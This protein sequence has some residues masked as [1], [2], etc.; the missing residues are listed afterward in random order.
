[1]NE[2]FIYAVIENDGES[3]P[4][5]ESRTGG[6]DGAPLEIVPYRDLAAVVSSIDASRFDTDLPAKRMAALSGKASS[7]QKEERLKADMLRYQQVNLFLLEHSGCSGMVPLRFGFT[8]RDKEQVEEVLGRVY[9]QLRTLLNNLKGKVELV[10]HASWD[11]PKILQEIRDE[12]GILSQRSESALGGLTEDGFPD[13][14]NPQSEI[15]NPKSIVEVGRMLFEGAEVRRKKFIE[16]IHNNLSPL[17]KDFSEGPRKAEAMILNR[18]YLVEREKE[19]LFDEAVNFLGT[20]YEGY[21]T[22][23]YIGPLPAYSF[24]NV[25]LNRGNFAMVD[26]ARKTLR[27]PEKASLGEIKASYRKLIL[28]FHPD[29]NPD[30]PRAEERCKD[31]VGAYEIVNAYCQSFQNFWESIPSGGERRKQSEYSF[32]KEEV[33]KVFIVKDKGTYRTMA[34]VTASEEQW[35]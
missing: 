29:R 7:A 12:Q 30:S 4:F 8:A 26:R 28:T 18:S 35:N 15:E 10:I 33:E 32:V 2:K 1:M 20:K 5:A 6:I 16:A 31:V 14:T 19:P 21:L 23:R 17:A 22:F 25:E 13:A 27:L 24:V 11:L 3:P 34:K 9:L